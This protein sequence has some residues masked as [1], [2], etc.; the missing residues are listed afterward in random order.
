MLAS[1]S[2]SW[3]PR[4]WKRWGMSRRL[5]LE[6]YKVYRWL[7]SSSCRVCVCQVMTG[8]GFGCDEDNASHG[9]TREWF[10]CGVMFPSKPTRDAC[11][12]GDCWVAEMASGTLGDFK[13]GCAS[14]VPILDFNDENFRYDFHSFIGCTW[15]WRS[16]YPW[17]DQT[18]PKVKT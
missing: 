10:C 11:D 5:W 1:T 13:V 15:Q 9:V 7:T 8:H 12:H 3:S 2:M 17:R 14:Q 18:F 6:G 16:L 4:C